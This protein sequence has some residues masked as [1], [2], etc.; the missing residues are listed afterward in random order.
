MRESEKD[1]IIVSLETAFDRSVSFGQHLQLALNECTAL[2]DVQRYII[3]QLREEN[4]NLI[5]AQ[6][7]Y[8]H[9]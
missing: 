6:D 3:T 1:A 4:S 2:C 7:H 9:L 5:A 8:D